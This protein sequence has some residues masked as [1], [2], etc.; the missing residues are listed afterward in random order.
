MLDPAL[1]LAPAWLQGAVDS[2][3]LLENDPA[4]LRNAVAATAILVYA[5]SISR[6]WLVAMSAAPLAVHYVVA[7]DELSPPTKSVLVSVDSGDG[8]FAEEV[9]GCAELAD[10]QLGETEVDGSRVTW[11]APGI[12][13]HGRDIEGDLEIENGT[14]LFQYQTNVETAKAHKEGRSATRPL[15]RTRSS[16]ARTSMP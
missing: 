6:P 14:A 10:A 4:K 5:T 1:A 15:S 9:N 12:V 13:K 11:L 7:E 3:P 8:S 16:S 2:Y